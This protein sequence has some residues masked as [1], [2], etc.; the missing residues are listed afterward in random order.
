MP[1]VDKLLSRSRRISD[2]S[3]LRGCLS[4]ILHPSQQGPMDVSTLFLFNGVTKF[5]HSSQ[6]HGNDEDHVGPKEVLRNLLSEGPRTSEE[7]WQHA[8]QQ[9][10]KSKRFMKKLLQQMCQ[11]GEIST[12]PL[13][14]ETETQAHHGHGHGHGSLNFVYSKT[15]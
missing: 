1:L 10:L 4:A 11:N 14:G 3:A 12:S 8:E 13:N 15:K 2:R 7:L 6:T 9:G 5:I